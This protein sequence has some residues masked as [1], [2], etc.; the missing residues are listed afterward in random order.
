[1]SDTSPELTRLLLKQ[2][3]E[4]FLYHEA[5]LLDARRYEAWLDL[6]TPDTHCWMPTRRYLP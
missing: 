1:M 5:E 3:V 4:D 2:E 6:L